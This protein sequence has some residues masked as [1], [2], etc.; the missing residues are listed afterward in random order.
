MVSTEKPTLKARL[1]AETK[2]Y[3]FIAA[4]LFLFLSA[5]TAYRQFVQ[6]EYGVAYVEYGFSLIEA[7]VLGKLIVIGR[8]LNLGERFLDRPLIIPTL[9]KTLCFG[10]LVVIFS[11]LE[12]II[13]G[14]WHHKEMHEILDSIV[15]RGKWEILCRVT[16]LVMVFLPMFATWEIGR[17]VG[18]GKLFKLFFHRRAD[19]ESSQR[20][21]AT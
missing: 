20:Q 12:R 19:A 21:S 17:F 16:M 13:G 9:Y 7:L 3:L 5:L 11:V 14:L 8:V 18:E 10:V 6:L 15:S 4:Y 2:T 1:L